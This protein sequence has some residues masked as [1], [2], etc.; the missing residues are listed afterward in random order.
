MDPRDEIAFQ[1]EVLRRACYHRLIASAEVRYWAD[2]WLISPDLPDDIFI[3][4][5]ELSTCDA[6]VSI[7][8]ELTA[9]ASGNRFDPFPSLMSVIANLYRVDLISFE[10]VARLFWDFEDAWEEG[11]G[12]PLPGFVHRGWVNDLDYISYGNHDGRHNAWLAELHQEF[13]LGLS[14]YERIAPWFV[15]LPDGAPLQTQ[16]PDEDH[17]PS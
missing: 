7:P 15:P 10:R 11:N 5:A 17:D 6:S 2:Q 14:A 3:A 8:E 12:S 9:L 1:A 13:E 4:L 16:G